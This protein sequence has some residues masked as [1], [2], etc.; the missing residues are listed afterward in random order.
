MLGF[1]YS[2]SKEYPESQEV[3]VSIWQHFPSCN[4]YFGGNAP[5]PFSWQWGD[6]A[7]ADPAEQ[8]LNNASALQLPSQSSSSTRTRTER[9]VEELNRVA[10]TIQ[11]ASSKRGVSALDDILLSGREVPGPCHA[12][13]IEWISQFY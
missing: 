5:P 10:E 2:Q 12:V 6:T 1:K 8:A 7:S 4:C 9:Q 13:N 3:S 11:P